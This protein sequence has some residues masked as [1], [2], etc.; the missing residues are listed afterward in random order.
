MG[1]TRSPLAPDIPTIAESGLP[2]FVA[3][4]WVGI[5]A[6]AHTPREIVARLNSDLVA[7]LESADTRE[8]L[9]PAGL[10]PSPSSPEEFSEVI[11]SEISRWAKVI[12]DAKIEVN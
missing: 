8:R 3:Q 7:I 12:R 2:G 6:P 9:L 11:R 1:P 10:E 4:S 5:V